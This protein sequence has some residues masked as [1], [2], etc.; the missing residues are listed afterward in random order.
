[1]I[2][3]SSSNSEKLQNQIMDSLTVYTQVF[4]AVF[5]LS[6]CVAVFAFLR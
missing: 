3:C 5:V 4:R 1:M 2:P 6:A